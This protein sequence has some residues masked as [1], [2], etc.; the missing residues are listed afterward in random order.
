MIR[1]M[2][3]SIARNRKTEVGSCGYPKRCDGSKDGIQGKEPGNA[4]PGIV[5]TFTEEDLKQSHQMIEKTKKPYIFVGGQSFPG[6]VKR[7]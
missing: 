3:F 1:F 7:N 4:A 5:Q 6:P 2:S